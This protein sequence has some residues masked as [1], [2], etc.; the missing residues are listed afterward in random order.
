MKLIFVICLRKDIA[1]EGLRTIH[2]MYKI[3]KCLE[4]VGSNFLRFCFALSIDCFTVLRT[5][6]FY[7]QTDWYCVSIR[8]KLALSSG[9]CL[10]SVLRWYLIFISMQNF[11]LLWL[12]RK[13]FF[14]LVSFVLNSACLRAC[15]LSI[16]LL[17]A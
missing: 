16:S 12:N 15:A 6:L 11:S 13:D 2:Y 14:H 7:H 4:I 8:Q 10:V 9:G 3:F 1:K 5:K 17:P